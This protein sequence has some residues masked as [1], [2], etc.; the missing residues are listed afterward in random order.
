MLCHVT[1]IFTTRLQAR[2]VRLD[3][4]PS[5][6][7]PA[8]KTYANNV[9]VKDDLWVV[10]ASVDRVLDDVTVQR[11]LVELGLERTDPALQ[12]GMSI[13]T[14]EEEEDN[15]ESES[16]GASPS[17]SEAPLVAYFRD[18]PADAQIYQMRRVLLGR[19]DRLNT[20]VEICQASADQDVKEEGVQEWEEDP[21]D[22][23]ADEDEDETRLPTT[24]PGPLPLSNFLLDDLLQAARLLATQEEFP[25][26][27]VLYERH[28]HLLW[29]YR[30]AILNAIPEHV[31][32]SLYRDILP[33]LD[34]T[35]DAEQQFQFEPW[36]VDEDWTEST[37]VQQALAT[38]GAFVQ[39]VA[40]PPD[41]DTNL[42]SRPESLSASELISWYEGRV[43][44]ILVSTGLTD[45]ALALVQHG[46]S[47]GIPGMDEMGEELNLLSRLVYDAR[48]EDEEAD[49]EWTL[50]RW[51]AMDPTTVVRAYLAHSTPETVAADIHKLVMP[52]LFV[53]EARAERS[54]NPDPSIF[55]RLLDE[56]IL[57]APLEFVAAIFE[58]SKP[59]LPA[60]HRIIKD[61]ENMAHLALSCLYGSDKL[62][63]W[64]TM[65]QIFECLPAWD[66]N[67]S[68]EDLADEAHKTIASL[69]AF[70]TPTTARPRC[71]PQDLLV[72]FKPL[73]ATSLSR[74]LDVLDVHLESGEILSRWSVPAPL[75]WFL[76]SANDGAQQRAWATR[77][78]RRAGGSDDE[79]GT[80]GDWE[81][82]LED[83][84]KLSGTND[85]GLNSAFGL[86]DQQEVM[87]IFFTGLLSTGKFD[88]AKDLLRS[89]RGLLTLDSST[90][91]SV[92]LSCSREFYDN[93][94][95]G[96]YRF[97]D[98][99][100]AYECVPAQSDAV[101]REREFIEATSR[102]AS[103]NVMSGPGTPITP[104][105]I[106]LTKDRLSLVSRV[107]SSNAD[108]YKYTEVILDLVR[109]L[110]YRDDPAAEV[111]ALAMITDTALQAEDFTR[112]YEVSETMI[113]TVLGLRSSV[114]GIDDPK[115][116][117]A[118]EVCWV[119]CLQLGRQP[120][121]EDVQKK[122]TLLGRA[123][124][125]CPADKLIDVLNAWRRLQ[126]EDLEERKERLA[127]RRSGPDGSRAKK[128]QSRAP[129]SPSSLAERFQSLHMPDLHMPS[130]PLV[131][132]PDAAA[133]A[134][135]FSRV[136]ANFPFSIGRPRSVASD[137]SGHERS[138]SGERAWVARPDPAEVSAQANRVFQK[139]IGWLLGADEDEG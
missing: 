42:T 56:Y 25:A 27:R 29:P 52:Y 91:E 6:W 124:E 84:I 102:I 59:T 1:T 85:A 116:Q 70:V 120:A 108:S 7:H 130:S 114:Q 26:I 99:K 41:L 139:G 61:D 103:F 55:T 65:S 96:N 87:R 38:S 105:E 45:V 93:A 97:G 133:I 75:R 12:R 111:K 68:N 69:G 134:N 16:S 131:S 86:L 129:K 50:Q 119:A 106:R 100:L 122:M 79:L 138:R 71:T 92:A 31:H 107:L 101:I 80:Q 58:A 9:A 137:G 4:L 28:G 48:F 110:G 14:L 60:A 62:N 24:E 22:D 21:W 64:P 33:A 10:A 73:P 13:L 76:Q 109:K 44:R 115:V 35:Q 3:S 54:G 121:F 83:M 34:P 88:I 125:F 128:A 81:W 74:A 43:E 132:T 19:L 2:V 51:K 37:A 118:S 117:D 112:A 17:R 78:A 36:R 127:K 94:N 49:E 40:L 66:S 126:S 135:T 20:Y 47:Q 104:L 46:G 57:S 23:G 67:E 72:F 18:E 39:D 95:S 77:L 53:L 8:L 136:A 15:E 63:E 90:I 89:R 123:L 113:S 11:A 32:P 30:L 98:M 82:L 5:S